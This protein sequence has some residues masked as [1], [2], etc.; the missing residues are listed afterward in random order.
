[1]LS[2]KN[3]TLSRFT[4]R[5]S[6][7]K[8]KEQDDNDEDFASFDSMY[9]GW[10]ETYEQA[11]YKRKDS[12]SPP[13]SP[14]LSFSEYTGGAKL[15][16]KQRRPSFIIEQPHHYPSTYYYDVEYNPDGTVN[17]FATTAKIQARS[18]ANMKRRPSFLIALDTAFGQL[19]NTLSSSS[20]SFSSASSEKSESK[21]RA[22]FTDE[23]GGK[24]NADVKIQFDGEKY[25]YRV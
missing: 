13:S 22:R 18:S 12:S 17:T 8:L 6:F 16:R 21:R 1:M 20:S 7:K 14:T 19:K 23:N 25:V 9:V 4:E 24:V 11:T 5:L 2:F 3:S 15:S 10:E